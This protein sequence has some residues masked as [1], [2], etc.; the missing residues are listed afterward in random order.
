MNLLDSAGNV[1]ATTTTDANG[2]YSFSKLPAGDYRV[3]VDTTG[4]LKGLDQTEDP[5][6]V[7]DSTSGTISLSNANRTQSGVNFGYIENN[8]ISGTIFRDEARNGVKDPSDPRF[9]SVKVTLLDE[10]GNVV[11]TTTT[12]ANGAYKFSHLPDGKYRVKVD[13]TGVLNGLEVTLD[14]DTLK[15]SQSELIELGESNP[16]V[17]NVDFGYMEKE[18]PPAPQPAKQSNPK[19]VPSKLAR[20]GAES[21]VLGLGVV[22]LV[23]GGALLALRRRGRIS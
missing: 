17:E 10:N 2:A 1:V 18:V 15:D 6:G 13:T 19:A 23:S 22:A 20:T 8:S 21:G 3:K 9:P 4:T 11:E 5:D 12:D 14:P 16:T 7:A